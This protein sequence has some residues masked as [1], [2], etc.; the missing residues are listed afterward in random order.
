MLK[1]VIDFHAHC[2][3]QHNTNYTVADVS[4]TLLK[5]SVE[6]TVIS[7][8]SSIVSP[9]YG[10]K[11]LLKLSSL[12]EFVLTYWVNPYLFDWQH[13]IDSLS[14]KIRIT[15][16]KLHPTANIYEPTREFLDPV[17]KY[18]RD[19][20]LF[21]TYHTDTFRSTPNKLI[22]L[23]LEYPDV[24]VVLIHMDDPINS[25]F[26]AKRFSNVYLETS[27]VER[28]WKY[29]A[30]VRIALDSVENH[31]I[32]FGTDFPYGFD[33]GNLRDSDAP[34]RSYD[35][36]ISYY[37]ELLPSDIS[38]KILYWNA[39]HFLERYGVEFGDES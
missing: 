32:F 24:D 8:L 14:K 27:W 37:N 5:N 3:I 1:H 25:I 26:L 28:K 39:R 10:E 18:C 19:R 7:S 2:G 36:C 20:K 34:V 17:F 35:D 15:A 4:R 16:I 11:E 23:L 38:E 30:P 31:K 33:L 6:K 12:P 13:R 9:D 21:I 29:I 22:E